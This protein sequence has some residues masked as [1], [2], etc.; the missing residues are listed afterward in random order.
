MGIMSIK[1][2]TM[3]KF[4]K[5]L[6]FERTQLGLNQKEMAEKLNISY[7]TYQNYELITTNNREPDL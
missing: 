2:D 1:R 6:K 5:N 3:I 7:R 4:S